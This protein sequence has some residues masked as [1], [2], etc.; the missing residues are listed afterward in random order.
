[1][2]PDQTS[3]RKTSVYLDAGQRRRLDLLAK[4]T[5]KARAELIRAA[6]DSY[7]PSPRTDRNFAL[8]CGFQRIDSDPRPISQI[9]EQE[10]IAAFGE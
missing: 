10:L 9:P 3:R 7:D 5:G 2:A 4:R 6:I 8:A 1:M